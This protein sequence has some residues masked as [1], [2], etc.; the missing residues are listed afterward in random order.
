MPESWR[1]R[2][3]DSFTAWPGRSPVSTLPGSVVVGVCLPA[4]ETIKSPTRTPAPLRR[5]AALDGAHVDALAACLTDLHPEVCAVRLDHAAAADQPRRDVL[6]AV[7]GNREADPRCRGRP[8]AGRWW[9]ASGCRSQPA[10]VGQR[11]PELPGLRARSC[12]DDRAQRGAAGLADNAPERADDPFERTLG[13]F[14]IAIARSPTFTFEES[15]NV[16]G[17]RRAFAILITARSSA[18]KLPTSVAFNRFPE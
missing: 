13:G 12:L 11:P 15:P 10:D 8:A 9:R 1:C 5:A 4:N 6:D 14:P 2:S 18:A 7:A 17:M 16:A 3:P